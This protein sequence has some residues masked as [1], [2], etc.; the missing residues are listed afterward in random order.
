MPDNKLQVPDPVKVHAWTAIPPTTWVF[1]P[2]DLCPA[3]RVRFSRG[4]SW[5]EISFDALTGNVTDETEEF[6]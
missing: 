2:G 4:T 3:T 5:L 6:R 1:Q